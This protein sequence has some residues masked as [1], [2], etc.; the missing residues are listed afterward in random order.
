MYCTVFGNIFKTRCNIANIIQSVLI[1]C[2]IILDIK[3]H[4]LN[5]NIF[6]VHVQ[7]LGNIEDALKI[8]VLIL[9]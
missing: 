5:N 8:F 3:K 4:C 9:Q 1:I 2:N 7:E 6:L